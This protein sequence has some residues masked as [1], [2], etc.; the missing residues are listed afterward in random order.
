MA[1][2]DPRFFLS[3]LTGNVEEGAAAKLATHNLNRYFRSGGFGS[4][5][6]E[7]N[8]LPAIALQ[9]IEEETAHTFA[10]EQS[11]IIGDSVR[12]IECARVGGMH[13]VAVATGGDSREILSGHDPDLLLDSLCEQQKLFSFLNALSS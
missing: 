13:V 5:A 4:D 3:I 7:R 12:D 10:P 11:V 6:V 2:D 8:D 9:R 1:Y